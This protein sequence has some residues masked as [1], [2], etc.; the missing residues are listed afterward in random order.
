[1]K[2]QWIKVTR[3]SLYAAVVYSV[4]ESV[5]LNYEDDFDLLGVGIPGYLLSVE[6]TV[7]ALSGGSLMVEVNVPGH[8]G[9][10]GEYILANGARIIVASR[11]DYEG[12]ASLSSLYSTAPARVI[13]A[14]SGL[15]RESAR[16]TAREGVEYIYIY[17]RDG[18]LAVLEGERG[19]VRIP[20]LKASVSLHTHPPGACG[21][22]L[23]DAQS[24]LDLLSEGGLA[25]AAATTRC[26]VVMYRE[27]LVTE[28][29]YITIR[30]LR[31]R[32][33]SLFD[34][35]RLHLESIRL[36]VVYY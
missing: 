23:A 30:S 20:F 6:D 34:P 29:D 36:E 32:R 3:G 1:M 8:R 12:D 18:R 25:E 21:L 11:W 10:L 35:S 27:G 33:N 14:D 22:S 24:G 16:K 9:V 19:A 28:D 31:R 17:T 5:E 7:S 4:I 2:E 26:A 15:I 13:Q